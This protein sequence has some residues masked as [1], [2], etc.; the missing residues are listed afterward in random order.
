VSRFDSRAMDRLRS[1]SF[2]KAETARVGRVNVN[3]PPDPDPL[4]SDPVERFCPQC[5]SDDLVAV[6][7]VFASRAGVRALY[8]CRR[9]TTESWLRSTDR[10]IGAPDRRAS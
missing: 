3:T 9:C 6:G 5:R 2:C 4:P 7:R 8:R 1:L 10:R